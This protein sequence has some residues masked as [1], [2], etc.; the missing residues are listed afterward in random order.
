MLLTATPVSAQNTTA[1]S[2][3]FYYDYT[4]LDGNVVGKQKKEVTLGAPVHDS[5]GT[6]HVT[7]TEVISFELNDDFDLKD[8]L[9]TT[10]RTTTFSHDKL[11]N[12]YI[13]NELVTPLEVN[14]DFSSLDSGGHWKYT[15]YNCDSQTQCYLYTGSG[16]SYNLQDVHNAYKEKYLVKNSTNNPT[17]SDFKLYATQAANSVSIYNNSG[18][19][20]ALAIAGTTGAIPFVMPLQ[21]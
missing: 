12:N 6:I 9:N 1:T 15:N 7:V 16:V 5:N 13:D 11:G 14:D 10:T 8:K 4:D 20:Y 19:A 2:N 21:Q 18:I 17:I 3:V